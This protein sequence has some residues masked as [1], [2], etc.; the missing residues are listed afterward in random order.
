MKTSVLIDCS[1]RIS[2]LFLNLGG[3]VKGLPDSISA[4]L[5][6]LTDIGPKQLAEGRAL[7]HPPLAF[8]YYH[9][10]HFTEAWMLK[11]DVQE[12]SKGIQEAKN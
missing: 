5:H 7:S 1:L 11:T 4:A 2:T 6:L 10:L 9:Q 3:Q 8:R 12:N